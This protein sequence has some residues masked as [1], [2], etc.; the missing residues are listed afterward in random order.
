M[1]SQTEQNALYFENGFLGEKRS[2]ILLN[3]V[4]E[5]AGAVEFNSEDEL[6]VQAGRCSG[7]HSQQLHEQRQLLLSYNF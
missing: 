7:S 3:D 1:H 2:Q 6:C 4:V 5:C